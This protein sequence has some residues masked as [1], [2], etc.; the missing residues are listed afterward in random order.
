[1]AQISIGD[2]MGSAQIDV[3]DTSLAGKSQLTALTTAASEVIAALPKPVTDPTFEDAAFAA[4]F[5]KPS[6]LLEGNSVDVKASVNSTLSVSRNSDSPLFGTDDYDPVNIDVGECWAAFELD[7]LLDAS[8]AVPLPDGFGVS[9]EASTAPSF[10][11]Y[12]LIP[13]AQAPNTTLGQAIEHT[14]DTFSILDSSGDVLSISQGV[15]YTN[16][17]SGTI[18]VGGSWALPLSVNQLSL[19]D[20]NLPFNSSI[21]VS[22]ALTVGINGDIA[23]T[24]EFS[25]RF[26]RAAPNLLRIGLYKKQGI[27]FD[28][29]FTAAAGLVANAGNTDLINEFF[30][31]VDPGI[32]ISSLQPGDAAK[33]QNVLNDSLDRSLAIAF[34][35]AWSDALSDAAA[36]VYEVDISAVDQATR[37]A[38]DGALSGNWSGIASLPNARRIRN[39]ITDTVETTSAFTVNFLGLYN[40]RSVEDFVRSMQVMTNPEDGSVVVTDSATAALITTAST[41]LAADPGRLRAAIYEGFVATATYKALLAG[42]GMN[43]AFSAT[44]TLLLYEDSMEYRDA[45][46]QLNAGEVLGVMPTAV[47]TG[48]PATGSPVQH[49]RFAASCN[50]GNDDVLR[51]FFSDINARTPRTS[52]GLKKIG[53]TVLASLL[54]PQDP[55]DQE[56]IVVLGSDDKW[57]TMDANPAQIVPPFYSDWYDITEWASAIATVGPL[58]AD[59]IAF[60]KTVQGDPTAN[61]A[62]MQKRAGLALALDSA[63]HNTKA[64]FNQNFPICVMATLAGLTPGAKRL[65]FEAAWNGRTLFSNKPAPQVATAT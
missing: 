11:T 17:V 52:D 51:F 46:T 19:A 24:S 30:T 28:V 23:I 4:V 3:S 61:P 47:K 20:A 10:A 48:L 7:T 14:L 12:V 27:T 65:V 15:I 25:V 37:N 31:A 50:Y 35:A 6:I 9:F 58:L 32:D 39:V 42:T 64:A 33:I 26:R 18:R 56:R 5:E 8:V 49:A 44:Q 60:A 53:R 34:N 43:P 36:M 57:A 41:P 54:D 40:Y 63:T 2:L 29:S 59:T 1:M 45:L 21:S 62:F 22:P 16:D 38:I 13:A 55:T